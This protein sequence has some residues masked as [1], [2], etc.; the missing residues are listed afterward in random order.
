MNVKVT[1]KSSPRRPAQEVPQYQK[2]RTVADHVKDNMLCAGKQNY[3]QRIIFV[4]HHIHSDKKDRVKELRKTLNKLVIASNQAATSDKLTGL[5]M[6]Y[7]EYSVYM[8]EGGE[9]NI[10]NFMKSFSGATKEF[11]AEGKVVLIYNNSN[12]RFFGKMYYAYAIP[13]EKFSSE[14]LE[15]HELIGNIIEKVT[16]I[17]LQIVENPATIDDTSHIKTDDV[18][19]LPQI[20]LLE[21][22]LRIPSLQSITEF[23]DIFC[24]VPEFFDYETNVWPHPYDFLPDNVFDWGKFDVNLTKQ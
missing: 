1:K 17:C 5:M 4:V 20:E 10:G 3:H 19:M 11:F 7:S 24:C 8:V 22:I 18:E 6:F 13:N 9:E 12:R 21:K 14:N 16:K 23:A 15:D 2:R